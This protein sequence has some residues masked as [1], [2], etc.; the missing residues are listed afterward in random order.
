MHSLTQ[1][2]LWMNEGVN[3]QPDKHVN[4]AGSNKALSIHTAQNILRSVTHVCVLY[5]VG[6]Q[7]VEDT[8]TSQQ[9]PLST[10]RVFV[11]IPGAVDPTPTLDLRMALVWAES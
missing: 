7:P 9:W 6:S 4:L 8:P 2:F 11:G 1:S 10:M 3:E 5:P